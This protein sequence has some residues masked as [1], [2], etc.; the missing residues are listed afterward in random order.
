MLLSDAVSRLAGYDS[1][2]EPVAKA[3]EALKP[4]NAINVEQLK[5]QLAEA[6][7]NIIAA[8]NEFIK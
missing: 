2:F 4:L 8:R 6:K 3:L 1:E 5:T 7:E